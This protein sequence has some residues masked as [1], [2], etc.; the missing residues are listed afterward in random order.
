M[1]NENDRWLLF[2]LGQTRIEPH[3]SCLAYLTPR[4]TRY[5]AIHGNQA[6]IVALNYIV[7]KPM[8]CGW[9]G[10]SPKLRPKDRSIVMIAWDDVKWASKSA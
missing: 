10:M 3:G 7:H 1:V 8:N 9:A 4:G 2:S 6:N 5:H